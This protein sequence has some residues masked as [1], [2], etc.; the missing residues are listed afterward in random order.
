[1]Y[2]ALVAVRKFT[3]ITAIWVHIIYN[4]TYC[5]VSDKHFLWIIFW[6]NIQ[7]RC[8]HCACSAQNSQLLWPHSYCS[9]ASYEK[10]N[11][12]CCIW[13]QEISCYKTNASIGSKVKTGGCATVRLLH[14]TICTYTPGR[15]LIVTETTSMRESN[16]TNLKLTPPILLIVT[17]VWKSR[18]Y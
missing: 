5:I 15:D 2:F 1:M 12:M 17:N 10:C 16:G 11:E 8:F 9:Q 18:M 4:I 7:S 3:K 13:Q 6:T 14:P